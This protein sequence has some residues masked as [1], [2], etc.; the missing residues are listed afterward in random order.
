VD[1]LDK[2]EIRGD[3]PA[4]AG[5]VPDLETSQLFLDEPPQRSTKTAI[6]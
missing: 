4:S 3:T 5:D 1:A 6:S 2:E